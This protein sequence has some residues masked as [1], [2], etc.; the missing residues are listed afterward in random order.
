MPLIG[1]KMTSESRIL[2]NKTIVIT[3]GTSGIGYELV[4]QL[5]QHNQVVVIARTGP[6][7]EAAARECANVQT[8]GANLADMSQCEQVADLIVKNH[9]NI[10]VLI[11]N[12]AIQYPATM[13]DKDFNLDSISHEINLNFTAVC[14]LTALLLPSLLQAPHGGMIVNMNSGLAL[15]PKTGS[16]VYCACKAAM[17][18]FSQ[19]L[20]YQLEGTQLKVVQVFLP[21]VDTPMTQGRGSGKISA[22]RA[23]GDI[24]AAISKG[25]CT[26]NVGKVKA[27]RVLFAL[28]PFLARKIL[29]SG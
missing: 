19:S 7:L 11:N 4:K 25:R 17:H 8:Y 3:G 10:D 14:T 12:A 22:E 29:K 2:H 28:A 5:A 20:R 15:A 26:V 9:P 6:R 16:A 24:L 13:L 27:L 21:L 1:L 18:S 23:A